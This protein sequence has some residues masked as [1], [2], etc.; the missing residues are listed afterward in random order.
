V[1]VAGFS[2]GNLRFTPMRR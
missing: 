2:T 1:Q